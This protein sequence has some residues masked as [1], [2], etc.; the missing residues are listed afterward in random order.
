MK[1]FVLILQKPLRIK[2]YSSLVALIEDNSIEVLGVSKS[3]LEKYD[4]DKF[5][6]VSNKVVIAKTQT[7]SSGDVRRNKQ[8]L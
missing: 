2:T 6:Y 8:I 4:F 7:Q 5:K 1:T 3:K